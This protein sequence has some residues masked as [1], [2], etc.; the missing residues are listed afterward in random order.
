MSTEDSTT[1]MATEAVTP[2]P[3]TNFLSLPGEIRNIIYHMVLTIPYTYDPVRRRFGKLETNLL[4]VN[5]KVRTESSDILHGANIWVYVLICA[6]EADHTSF[7]G[8]RI[9]PPG[10]SRELFRRMGPPALFIK[11]EVRDEA[12]NGETSL[13][14]GYLTAI[15]SIRL[16]VRSLWKVTAKD[17]IA[18]A[19]ARIRTGSEIELPIRNSHLSLCLHKPLF[20]SRTN[21]AEICLE[22]FALIGTLASI[23]IQGDIDPAVQKKLLKRM[24]SLFITAKPA[25]DIGNGYL[26]QGD[27]ARRCGDHLEARNLFDHGNLFVS[28]AAEYLLASSKI[29][30]ESEEMRILSALRNVLRSR[31]ARALLYTGQFKPAWEIARNMMPGFEL[32]DVDRLSVTLCDGC[33]KRGLDD[34]YNDN[35]L[36]SSAAFDDFIFIL[37]LTPRASIRTYFETFPCTDKGLEAKW[38]EVAVG[39]GSMNEDVHRAAFDGGVDEAIMRA[40]NELLRDIARYQATLAG[41]PS[42]IVSAMKRQLSLK[43]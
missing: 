18:A 35:V 34:E 13:R 27:V 7:R 24:K 43:R 32:A 6:S 10:I 17:R 5:R 20:H 39:L 4:H 15:E 12:N 28:H 11:L 25:I 14:G 21:L 31:L 8:E 26:Q 9:L 37:E 33:A 16:F 40:Q 1:N 36:P 38:I 23:K 19:K 30:A 22:P 29:T 41:P 3:K 2:Q 42:N